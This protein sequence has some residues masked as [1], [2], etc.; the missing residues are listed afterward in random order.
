MIAVKSWEVK[1]YTADQPFHRTLK[2][3]LSPKLQPIHNLGVGMVILPPGVKSNPHSHVREEET[4]YII[5][6]RGEIVVGDERVAVEPEMLVVAPPGK[7]H[8]VVN[9]GD[10]SLKA[11]WVF[12]PAGPEEEHIR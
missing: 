2:C 11:L 3:L 4:W 5:S 10:E 9:T 8:Q 6:G 12:A 7:T 1:G